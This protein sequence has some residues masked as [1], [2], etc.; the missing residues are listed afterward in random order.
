M[1]GTYTC[2]GIIPHLLLEGGLLAPV[3]LVPQKGKEGN[4]GLAWEQRWNLGVNTRA[5]VPMRRDG[6]LVFALPGGGEVLG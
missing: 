1:T 3:K 4:F 5:P 2:E 6:R